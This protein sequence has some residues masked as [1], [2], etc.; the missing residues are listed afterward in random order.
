[1]RLEDARGGGNEERKE[2]TPSS[3][4]LFFPIV[5]FTDIP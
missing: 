1:M 5:P 3:F 4:S 2:E